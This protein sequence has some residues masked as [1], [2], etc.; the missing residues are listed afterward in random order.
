M[1]TRDEIRRI[2]TE[3]LDFTS[4]DAYRKWI[5]EVRPSV[6][7]TPE[8]VALLSPDGIDCRAFWRVCEELFGQDPVVNVA[9]APRG[10]ALPSTGGDAM[11]WNRQNLKIAKSFG[12]TSFLEE[13]AAS[14]IKTLE[15]GPG[16][17]S[18]KNFIET[19]TQHQYTG[20]DVYPRIPGVLEAT[21]SGLIPADFVE[22]ERGE[23]GYVVSTNVF[24]HFSAK[25]RAQTFADAH[26]LL[27]VGGIFIFNLF[28]DTGKM[29]ANLRDESGNAWCDHY[30]QYTEVPRPPDLL[31]H[32]G[33]SFE[34]LYITHRYDDVMNFV[35]IKRK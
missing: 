12:I 2:L 8:R 4:L 29:P 5:A 28:V 9:T 32:I 26:Q 34:I 25:Q 3:E 33:A 19:H 23:F 35:C 13:H 16:Y 30:G 31:K 1:K 15:I 24:Q 14:R 18:L 20:I 11:D 22:R 21:T 17:G 27:R 10:G 7:P 6:R